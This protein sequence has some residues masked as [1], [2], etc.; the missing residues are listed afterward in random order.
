MR[1]FICILLSMLIF[2]SLVACSGSSSLKIEPVPEDMKLGLGVEEASESF[3]EDLTTFCKENKVKLNRPF[4]KN[5]LAD[6]S[7]PLSF[8]VYTP[9]ESDNINGIMLG[10]DFFGDKTPS[11]VKSY[12]VIWTNTDTA[13]YNDDAIQIMAFY[14]QQGDPSYKYS[15]AVEKA[16]ELLLE[17]IQSPKDTDMVHLDNFGYS[18]SHV[19]SIRG[20]IECNIE[21]NKKLLEI[22]TDEE[23]I[24][25]IQGKIEENEKKLEEYPEEYLDIAFDRYTFGV[26]PL[27]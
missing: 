18:K 3:I 13:N 16:E 10:I 17:M 20:E 14:L 21:K 7:A 22:L 9:K 8:K 1:K 25:H 26:I 23:D 4:T 15:D 19:F 2:V 6:Y 11:T 5:Y 24:L 27:H 12:F